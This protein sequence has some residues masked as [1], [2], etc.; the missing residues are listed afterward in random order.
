[1]PQNRT[2]YLIV[3]TFVLIMLATL[4][5]LLLA[6]S[7]RAGAT[8]FYFL[9]LPNVAGLKFGTPVLFEGYLA[10]QI[11]DI[12]PTSGGVAR[13]EVRLEV[14]S[15]I[16]IPKDSKAFI[17]QP[18]LLS[19]RAISISAG[20]S[21]DL[22]EANS[23]LTNGGN[24]GLAVLPDLIGNGQNLITDARQLILQLTDSA[25]LFK[26]WLE[27][28][29]REVASTYADLPLALQEEVL[30]LGD[31]AQMLLAEVREASHRASMILDEN[32]L[33]SIHETIQNVEQTTAH[34]AQASERL[35]TLNDN[36]Q[37]IV[38]LTHDFMADNKPDLEAAIID[39]R[40]A[41]ERVS[42]RIDAMTYNLEGTS[43]NM[44]EFTREIRLNPGLLLGGHPPKD[45]ASFGE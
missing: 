37:S 4:I 8:N 24:T 35:N 40:Y 6:I 44:Y 5:V 16:E 32:T 41:L 28:D 27:D 13:F 38:T 33:T 3:G 29:F 15:D 31:E 23:F 26:G 39:L 36:I 17:T 18:N 30:A 45:E 19:G 22:L 21:V 10:G 2:T 20:E 42:L 9:S 12:R 25:G 1:M 34:L 7:G 14:L 43:Q 11:H